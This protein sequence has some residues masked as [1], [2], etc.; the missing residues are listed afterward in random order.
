[1]EA[2]QI[3]AVL[4]EIRDQQHQQIKYHEHSL[5]IQREQFSLV[6]KQ[7][8]RTEQIQDRAEAIQEK[9][10]QIVTA[11]R[12]ALALILP[13]IIVLVIFLAWLLLRSQ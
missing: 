9:S 10:A 13:I 12:K 3:L 7:F 6:Q 4:T 2:Q 11:S 8:A 1:M 5:A